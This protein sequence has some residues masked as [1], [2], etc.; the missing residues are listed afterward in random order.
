MFRII[1]GYFRI[2]QS[3]TYVL[4]DTLFHDEGFVEPPSGIWVNTGFTTSFSDNGTLLTATQT[5]CTY[6]ANVGSTSAIYDFASPFIVEFDLVSHT[7]GEIQLYDGTTNCTRSLSELGVTSNK[8]VK[9][10]NDGSTV[11]YYVDDVEV[12]AKRYTAS[13]GNC[14]VGFRVNSNALGNI[15]FKNFKIYNY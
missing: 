13:L 4:W 1:I 9:V 8:K 3:E 5:F 7:N 12:T 2:L 10:V 6:F 11:K 15:T 14:R